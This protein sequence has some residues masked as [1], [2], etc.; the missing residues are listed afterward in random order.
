MTVARQW[1]R[2]TLRTR[3]RW[4]ER[5][6]PTANP[7]LLIISG[8][9]TRRARLSYSARY[10]IPCRSI[11][12][13]YYRSEYPSGTKITRPQTHST[14]SRET[15]PVPAAGRSPLHQVR[16]SPGRKPGPSS[17]SA[18]VNSN[19]PAPILSGQ[20]RGTRCTARE[21]QGC[22]VC[23]ELA[24]D[25]CNR[26]AA[27]GPVAGRPLTRHAGMPSRFSPAFTRSPV[28]PGAP[29]RGRAGRLRPARGDGGDGGR[30]RVRGGRRTARA[31]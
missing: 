7:A 14:R 21:P 18:P 11:L 23:T 25:H 17:P 28:T 13:E 30:R 4:P 8:N 22:I 16:A 20:V 3:A 29:P 12:R 19:Y 9:R 24:D 31:P 10:L 27:P 2:T 6:P 1:A 15:S 5:P 26:V